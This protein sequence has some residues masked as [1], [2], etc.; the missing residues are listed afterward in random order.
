MLTKA[1]PFSDM[2]TFETI[3]MHIFCLISILDREPEK[4]LGD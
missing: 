3:H 1:Q 4:S 2:N